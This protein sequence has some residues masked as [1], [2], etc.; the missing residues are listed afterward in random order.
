MRFHEIKINS[1][2][3]ERF[4]FHAKRIE[5][6]ILSGLLANAVRHTPPHPTT[7]IFWD[8]CRDVLKAIDKSL[9]SSNPPTKAT[10]TI[11]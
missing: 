10:T 7:Q 9:K 1:H 2:G 8:R 5:L 3:D 4:I 11:F 6:S